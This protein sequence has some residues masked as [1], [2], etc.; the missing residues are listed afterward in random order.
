MSARV[1]AEDGARR[2][3]VR[4]ASAASVRVAPGVKSIEPGE[5]SGGMLDLAAAL[6]DLARQQVASA[7]RIT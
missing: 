4:A 7:Q 5:S 3:V 1:W 2:F 6:S